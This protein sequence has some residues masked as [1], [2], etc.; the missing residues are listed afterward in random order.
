MKF[1]EYSLNYDSALNQGLQVS[2]EDKNYFAKG[3]VEWLKGC[4]KNLKITPSKIL[5]FGCG[6]GTAVPYL[7]DLGENPSLLGLDDSPKSLLVAREHYS[8][9]KTNFQ[10]IHEFEPR[11]DLDLIYCNGVFHHIPP[12]ER[13]KTV[14]LIAKALKPGGVFSLW[15]NNPW[16]PGT[17]YVMSRIPF[18]K[19]AIPLNCLETKRLLEDQGFTVLRTDFLFIMPR[20]LK[21]LRWVEPLLCRA[22]LG[23]QYQVLAQKKS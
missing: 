22:P 17:R 8:Q 6:I 9:L 13:S 20:F 7:M 14:G 10:D 4:L 2:G 12:G 15:E 23:A 1:D 19:D 18:D 16:N 21:A 5:D 3:R 11:G